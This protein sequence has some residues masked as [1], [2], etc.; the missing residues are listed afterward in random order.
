MHLIHWPSLTLFH[1]HQQIL[2]S[3]SPESIYAPSLSLLVPW[4]RPILFFCLDHCKDLN[5]LTAS[6]FASYNQSPLSPHS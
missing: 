6:T 1:T 3:L 4:V 2:L 5:G